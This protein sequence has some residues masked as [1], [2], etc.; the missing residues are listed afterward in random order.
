MGL[1]SLQ[2]KTV[3]IL[4]YGNQGRAHA[5]NLRDSG[6][7]VVVGARP[8]GKAWKQA[9]A[10]GFAPRPF[11]Q[12]VG[13]SEVVMFLLPDQLIAP[14]FKDLVPLLEKTPKWIGF[15][16]GFAYHFGEVP[17]LPSCQYFLVAPK[18]AGAM[19][20][21]RYE[22]G[23]GLPTTFAVAKGSS[24][25]TH[26]LAEA[27]ARAIAGKT[28][29]IR[30]TTFQME[31]EGDLFGEQVVLVG[32]LME[33]MR[34][35]FETLV[36]NGHPP[37]MAFFDVCQE[38]QV[39]VDLFLKYGPVGMAEKISPTALYGAATRGPRIVGEAAKA[40]MQRVFDEVRSGDFAKE[41]LQEFQK[42]GKR[43]QA[44]RESAIGSD[45]E[46]AFQDL[47]V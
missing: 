12:A 45:W 9:E 40:E 30:E 44:A 42:G 22:A 35:A 7:Q 39:T 6:V 11:E 43:L 32:G 13:E 1:E 16:H 10:D 3:S 24:L 36:R 25:E 28:S 19:L 5:L 8:E 37:E 38:V 15:A 14:V 33:L 2:S 17:H 26:A 31:T 47:K 23:N 46:K 29:F 27:Y 18:G 41:L 4:G 21:S 20:R 34:A